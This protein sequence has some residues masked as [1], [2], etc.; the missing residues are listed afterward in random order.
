MGEPSKNAMTIINEIEQEKGGEPTITYA[1]TCPKAFIERFCS[2][3]HMNQE[4]T[5]LCLF[6]A[7][8]LELKNHIPENTPH[9]VAAG[10][11]YFVS[12]EFSLGLTR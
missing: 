12:Q 1:S 11:V 3:L 6:I 8:Q 10:I 2:K 4:L 9:S 7:H 5:Q